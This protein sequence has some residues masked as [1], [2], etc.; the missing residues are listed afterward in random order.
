MDSPSILHK[1]GFFQRLL[2]NHRFSWKANVTFLN[3]G[4]V[5]LPSKSI[6]NFI[7]SLLVSWSTDILYLPHALIARLF[8]HQIKFERF[9]MDH[10]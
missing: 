5:S 2:N 4:N 3:N 6:I 1:T 8:R 9:N 7:G 10:W